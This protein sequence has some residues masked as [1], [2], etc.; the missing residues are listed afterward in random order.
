MTAPATKRQRA[1]QRQAERAARTPEQ[2]LDRLDKMFGINQGAQRERAR[3]LKQIADRDQ[4]N[5]GRAARTVTTAR[6][7][8]PDA[9]PTP[10]ASHPASPPRAASASPAAASPTTA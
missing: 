8:R 5:R 6:T 3:L 4:N 9:A 2:Q 1:E 10:A 7:P